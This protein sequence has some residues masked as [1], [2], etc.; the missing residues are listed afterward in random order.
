MYIK[1]SRNH[2]GKKIKDRFRQFAKTIKGF[3]RE[4]II[5]GIVEHLLGSIPGFSVVYKFIRYAYD[6]RR[7]FEAPKEVYLPTN[8]SLGFFNQVTKRPQTLSLQRT[9]MI[10]SDSHQYLPRYWQKNSIQR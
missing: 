5:D 10:S 6:H 4:Y 1:V 7:D 2:F 8:T 9:Y 3:V